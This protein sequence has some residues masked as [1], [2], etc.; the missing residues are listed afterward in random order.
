ME[1]TDALQEVD[2]G[3]EDRLPRLRQRAHALLHR[4]PLLVRRRHALQQSLKRG[5]AA[6]GDDGRWE[7]ATSAVNPVDANVA[8]TIIGLEPGFEDGC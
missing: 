8:E 7:T 4:V 3:T 5:E 1:H 2:Q 6:R